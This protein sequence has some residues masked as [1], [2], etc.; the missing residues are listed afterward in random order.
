M[1]IIKFIPQEVSALT[2]DTLIEENFVDFTI[3]T[4]DN[5]K[6][7]TSAVYIDNED[8]LEWFYKGPELFIKFNDIHYN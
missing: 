8:K 5:E 7:I 2:L 4:I 1:N 3:N 6:L